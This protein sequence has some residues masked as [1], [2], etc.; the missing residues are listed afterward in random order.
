MYIIANG[1][2]EIRVRPHWNPD[3]EMLVTTLRTGS[4]FG[5]LAL[6]DRDNKRTATAVALRPTTLIGF[7]KPDLLEI[8]DRQPTMGV[9]ILYSLSKVLGRRLAETTELITAIR[10]EQG[11]KE[12]PQSGGYESS[13]H[14]QKSESDSSGEKE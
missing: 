1:T 9:K 14:T 10:E 12:R 5:E 13:Q 11:L 6:V 4:F 7:F 2:V 3:T 8:V